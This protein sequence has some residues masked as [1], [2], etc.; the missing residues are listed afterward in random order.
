MFSTF[1]CKMQGYFLFHD[2]LPL[3]HNQNSGGPSFWELPSEEEYSLHKKE[4]FAL[5][6]LRI[7]LFPKIRATFLGLP[8]IWII[9]FGGLY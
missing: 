9:V 7:W 3:E 4:E 8:I 2:E 6:Q 5:W 1:L